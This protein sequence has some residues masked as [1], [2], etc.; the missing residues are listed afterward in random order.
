M[1]VEAEIKATQ[2]EISQLSQQNRS[3][4]KDPQKY[5]NLFVPEVL[6]KTTPQNSGCSGGT[7]KKQKPGGQMEHSS[8]HRTEENN[9]R[10]DPPKNET[11]RY[12]RNIMGG[13]S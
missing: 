13:I 11:D 5:Q 4:K 1:D 7:L 10:V 9:M 12:W 6:C 2:R 8:P 3:T